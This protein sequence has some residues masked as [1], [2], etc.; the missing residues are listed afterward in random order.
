M[1]N[2]VKKKKVLLL[3]HTM[4]RGGASHVLALLAEGFVNHGYEV[5][6]T[7]LRIRSKYQI[8][9][10]VQTHALFKPDAE[11][12]KIACFKKISGCIKKSDADLIISFLIEVNIISIIANRGRK[13][14]IISER[15]DPKVAASKFVYVAS[16]LLYNFSDRVVFQSDRVCRYYSKSIQNKSSII[17]NPIDVCADQ[18]CIN[19]S[20]IVVAVGKLYPQKNHKLLIDAFSMLLNDYPEHQ[21][22]IYGEGP[23]R[24]ELEKYISEKNLAGNVILQGNHPNVQERI[25][26]AEM[27]V[28]SSDYEGLSNALLEAMSIGIPSISTNCAGSE[29]IINDGAN[30]LIVPVGDKNALYKAMKSLVENRELRKKIQIE[31]KKIRQKIDKGKIVGEWIQLAEKI[32]NE[33]DIVR[34]QCI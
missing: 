19:D 8:D 21:L 30:G 22:H 27:F 13:K 6:L 28:L 26:N 24:S 33:Q 20:H 11:P 5:D 4:A 32:I 16:K 25:S 1:C 7:F 2:T 34:Q 10:R 29:E 23:L 14:L 18:N 12:S 17:L 31:S 15:N 3:G 9:E